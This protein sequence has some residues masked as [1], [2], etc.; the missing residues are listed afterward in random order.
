M[1]NTRLVEKKY[2]R[3]PAFDSEHKT[4]YDIGKQNGMTCIDGN[5]VNKRSDYVLL[6]DILNLYKLTKHLKIHYSLILHGCMSIWNDRAKF[7]N[8][9]ILLDS[10]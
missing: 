3:K 7:K 1:D 8:F 9:R 10:G 2:W 6:H 4:I 5:K